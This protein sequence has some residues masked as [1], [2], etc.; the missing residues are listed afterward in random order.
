MKDF[1]ALI[2]N[3]PF[4]DQSVKGAYGKLVKMSKK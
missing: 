3:K 2:G 4:L 1:N